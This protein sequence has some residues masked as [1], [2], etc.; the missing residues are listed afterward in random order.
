MAQKSTLVTIIIA[1]ILLSSACSSSTAETPPAVIS[2]ESLTPD[3]IP[4]TLTA[5]VPTLD[6]QPTRTPRPFSPAQ[7]GSLTSDKNEFFTAAGNCIACHKNNIDQADNDVSFGEYWRSSMMANSAKD[8]YYL[9]GVSMNIDRFPEYSTAIESKCSPCHMPMAHIS[10]VFNGEESLIFGSEGYLDSQHPLH[11]MASDG[12]SCT[13]CHQIQDEGLGE[14]SSFS[15]GFSVDNDTP[16]GNRTLFG[17]FDLHQSSQNIMSK[18][19]G[20][21][22]LQ[23]DHLIESE[24]CATCHNLY[25]H[26]V[27]EDGSFSDEWFPEQTP[28]TEWLNSDFATQSTCQDCHM[29][30]AEGSVVLSSM[31]PGGPR[32]PFATHG[33]VGGNVYML[34]ILKNFGGEFGVQAGPEHFDATIERTLT[35]LQSNTAELSISPPVVEDSLLSFDVTTNSLT[36]HKLPTGYPS[37]RAWLHVRIEDGDGKLIFESGAVEE[38]GAIIGNDNDGNTLAFEAHYNEITSPDQVQIYESLMHDVSGNLTTVLLS[39]SA[40]IKDNRLLPTGFDK[41]IVTGDI[42][43]YGKALTDDNFTGGGDS[44]TYQID[45]GSSDGPYQ[46]SVELLYQSIS[47]RWAEDLSTYNTQQS[48][49]FTDYYNALSNQPVVLAVQVAHSD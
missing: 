40:Y 42:A 15:G 8:P 29:P 4:P 23:S 35:L 14:F 12:V 39:A 33:F 46:V 11:K 17:R 34:G 20:F 24:I 31:G 32:S 43:P 7:G 37:R 44:V 21:I 10:D 28:Y 26:Y 18:S 16:M 41:T 38:N 36:G 6:N 48:Q 47:Y 27:I 3:V 13:A 1:L 22:S 2:V 5:A 45:T 30:T 19:S 9:A 49:L 25:T